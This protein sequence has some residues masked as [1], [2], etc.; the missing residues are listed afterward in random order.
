MRF[1]FS[2]YA[3]AIHLTCAVLRRAVRRV[4]ALCFITVRSEENR[5]FKLLLT[6]IKPRYQRPR[7]SQRRENE[8]KGIE[9]KLSI[10]DAES[11]SALNVSLKNEQLQHN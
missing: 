8:R 6:L 4:C 3:I 2:L 11:N 1:L 10:R 7:Y 9:H 5:A